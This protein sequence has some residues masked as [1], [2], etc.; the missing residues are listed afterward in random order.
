MDLNKEMEFA[1]KEIQGASAFSLDR[2]RAYDGQSHTDNG[3]RG[4]EF[5]KG[6]TMRDMSDCIVLAMI[7]IGGVETENPIHDDIYKADLNDIDPGALIQNVM[8]NVEKMMGIYPNVPKLT[9]DHEE[10]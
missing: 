3:T 10:E 2:D 7:G 4:K 1:F 9:S 5:I 6:I 8:I